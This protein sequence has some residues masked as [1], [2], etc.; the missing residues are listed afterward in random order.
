MAKQRSQ[1]KRR[2]IITAEHIDATPERLAKGDDFAFVNPA[3][4]DSAEQ[5]IGLTRRFA[6]S[7]LDR[8]YKADRIDWRCWYAGGW[9]QRQHEAC[10]FTSSV[11]ANYGGMTSNG[12]PSYGLAR[13]EKQ[14]QARK[15]L[16]DA[17]RHIPAHML[18]YVDRLL[19]HDAMP[20]R[21]NRAGQRTLK[22]LAVAL[23]RLADFLLIPANEDR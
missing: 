2:I 7:H 21:R 19:L 17:R 10:R 18:G 13:T 4:I 16:H 22:D 1:R 6:A 5:P 23:S 9:Y 11:V 20:D 12:E 3:E 14:V 15:V 8:L